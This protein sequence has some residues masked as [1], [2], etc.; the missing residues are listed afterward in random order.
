MKW[1]YHWYSKEVISMLIT[2][3]GGTGPYKIFCILKYKSEKR[4]S[5]TH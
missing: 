4:G 3:D 5:K 2:D 1:F